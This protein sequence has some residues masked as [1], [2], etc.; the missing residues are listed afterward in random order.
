[1]IST[2]RRSGGIALAVALA[3]LFAAVRPG[4]A[5]AHPT[6]GGHGEEA[7]GPAPGEAEL[8]G[9]L[10]APCCFTQTLDVHESPLASELRREIRARMRA[11][12]A[13]QVIED[14]LAARYGD[15]IRAVPRGEDPRRTMSTGLGVA[16]AAAGAGLVLLVLR[17]TR[18][19]RSAPPPRPRTP[20]PHDVLDDRI[21]DELARMDG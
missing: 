1:M 2:C 21:D 5:S 6:L 15:A 18:R 7:E 16:T 8:E 20:T 19:A 3:A 10:V 11:G 12:E 17:W 14:D 9:R 4:L 13:P